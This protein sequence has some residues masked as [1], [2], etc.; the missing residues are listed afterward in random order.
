M[1]HDGMQTK[2]C[3]DLRVAMS[4]HRRL[5]EC[6]LLQ[7]QGV[8]MGHRAD[9]SKLHAATSKRLDEIEAFHCQILLGPTSCVV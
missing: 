5:T 6:V 4:N 1:S 9:N 2:C 8:H 7:L 3:V